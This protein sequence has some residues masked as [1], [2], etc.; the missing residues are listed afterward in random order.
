MYNKHTQRNKINMLW[1][2]F[3]TNIYKNVRQ[4]L[5]LNEIG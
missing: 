1:N 4:S 5:Y 3:F 2:V